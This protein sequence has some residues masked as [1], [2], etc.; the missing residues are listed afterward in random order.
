M[1]R[2]DRR[3]FL[4]LSTTLAAAGLSRPLLG[5][6]QQVAGAEKAALAVDC[7]VVGAGLS[8]LMAARTLVKEG[9]SRVL[10]LDA[11]DRVGGRTL[12]QSVALGGYAEAGGQWIGPT[13][14]AIAALMDEL[15]IP[16]FPT[17]DAGAFVDDTTGGFGPLALLDYGQAQQTINGLAAGIPLDAPW[18]A[19][20]AASLD[21][22][23]VQ[24]WM[25]ANMFTSGGKSLLALEVESTL[26]AA[27]AAVSMLYFLF[28]VHSGTNL[29][30][31]SELAQ[32]S[33]IVGGSQSIS[34]AMAAQLGPRVRL[35]QAVELIRHHEDR[36]VVETASLRV[37]AR[38]AVVAMMPKDVAKI[39]FDPVLP[40]ERVAL[41]DGWVG[42]PGAKFHAVY[43]TPFWRDQGKSGQAFS[44]T[45]FLALTFDNSPPDG[46]PGILIGF[47]GD[48]SSIPADPALRQQLVLESFEHFFGPEAQQNVDYAEYLWQDDPWAGGCVSPL[49]PGFLTGFGPALRTPVGP[50]HWAG[51]ETSE[52]W[53]G[54]M[55]GAVRAGERAALEV[56]AALG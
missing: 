9:Y 56:V 26:G 18:S 55:D 27:P 51:T 32:E 11:R 12:N 1:A 52:V 50:I 29:Q 45:Q 2:T 16:S 53:C 47:P 48:E 46:T 23:T 15:Q 6:A 4:K 54:Y 14:T 42:A 38:R 40:P 49:P 21:G 8:G 33:R 5:R 30:H 44:D 31:L 34:L 43:P 7:V 28:Y 24:Q 39:A 13:Q 19:P 37:H 10:V 22:M 3:R 25:D 35:N 41:Q 36:V 17:Y 20:D